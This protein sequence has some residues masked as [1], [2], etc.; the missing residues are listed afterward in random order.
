MFEGEVCHR[1]TQ[2]S[3][4]LGV[5]TYCMHIGRQGWSHFG[6]HSEKRLCWKPVTELLA[7]LLVFGLTDSGNRRRSI[8][9]PLESVMQGFYL[10][11]IQQGLV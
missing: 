10:A 7:K 3:K 4:P 11:C 2:L 9:V 8:P 1:Q 5:V 6:V